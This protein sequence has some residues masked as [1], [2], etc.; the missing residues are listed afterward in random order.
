MKNLLILALVFISV[1]ACA[2]DKLIITGDISYPIKI[3][4]MDKDS[5]FFT[6]D[7]LRQHMA[8]GKFKGMHSSDKF[9]T[10]LYN[11]PQAF[12][13]KNIGLDF[14]NYCLNKYRIQSNTGRGLMLVGTLVTLGSPLLAI[15]NPD[16]AEASEYAALAGGVIGLIGFVIEWNSLHWLKNIQVT[17]EYQPGLGY[18]FKF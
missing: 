10:Y 16:N 17:G 18:F 2:Q 6:R 8:Y 3:T 1:F 11:T 12:D 13:S 15:S 14:T 5:L 7:G 4:R 9:K